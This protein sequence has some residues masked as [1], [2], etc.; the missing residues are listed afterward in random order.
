M[1]NNREEL[2]NEN[3]NQ[4]IGRTMEVP[5]GKQRIDGIKKGNKPGNVLVTL[6]GLDVNGKQVYREETELPLDII[7]QLYGSV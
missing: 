1:E 7:E 3:F 6:T 2:P 5:R 4:Y